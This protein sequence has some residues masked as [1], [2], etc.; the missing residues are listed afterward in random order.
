[1]AGENWTKI[2]WK[3]RTIWIISEK[4]HVVNLCVSVVGVCVCVCECCWC[5]F[6]SVV[7]VS[8]ES[9]KFVRNQWNGKTIFVHRWIIQFFYYRYNL[10]SRTEKNSYAMNNF[11]HLWLHSHTIWLSKHIAEIKGCLEFGISFHA[12]IQDHPT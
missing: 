2:T 6:V 7:C 5:V 8:Q 12:A 9:Y 1:M 3:T 10:R 4:T 11:F